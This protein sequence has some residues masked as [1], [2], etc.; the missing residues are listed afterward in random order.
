M[1]TRMTR[2]QALLALGSVALVVACGRDAAQAPVP[3]TI[4]RDECAWC[5]MLID[6]ARLPAQFLPAGGGAHRFGEVGCLLAWMA[7]NPGT[8]GV[9][10]VTATETGAWMPAP[11]AHYLIGFLRTPMRFDITAHA[12]PPE[13]T[14]TATRATWGELRRKGAPDARQG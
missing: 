10:F 3:I 5:R 13:A 1:T 4:G 2:R 14:D 11:E 12:S 8:A 6:D 7:E 9:P